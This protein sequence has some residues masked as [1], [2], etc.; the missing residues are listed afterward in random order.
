LL[1]LFY[2]PLKWYNDI[3]DKMLKNKILATI[4]AIA[5]IIAG[6]FIFNT[7]AE[8]FIDYQN[9]QKTKVELFEQGQY[10]SSL[11]EAGIEA[12]LRVEDNQFKV[13]VIIG[14]ATTAM[15]DLKILMIE[16][17]QLAKTGDKIYP[18]LG[19]IDNQLINLIP[20]GPVTDINKTGLILSFVSNTN[21]S[22]VLVY[23]SYLDS[24]NTR[25]ERFLKL[26][27]RI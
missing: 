25:V 17:N 10:Q 12:I 3:G 5:V 22:E 1:S 20:A 13:S 7:G 4:V 15:N 14:N 19:L 26:T 2:Y 6:Y 9:Y 21:I 23:I 16:N 8:Q 11:V 18:S 24:T 27:P